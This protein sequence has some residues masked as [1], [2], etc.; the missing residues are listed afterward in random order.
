V[1]REGDRDRDRE[2]ADCVLEPDRCEEPDREACTICAGVAPE[3]D[4]DGNLLD[5]E[6]DLDFEVDFKVDFE[7][8]VPGLDPVLDLDLVPDSDVERA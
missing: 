8:G 6:F 4:C 2:R 7:V 5:L 1:D 3:I